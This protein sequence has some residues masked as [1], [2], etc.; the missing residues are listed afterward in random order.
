MIRSSKHTI[1]FTNKN[2]LEI[3]HSFLNE[4]RRVAQIIVDDIWLNGYDNFIPSKDKL[5]LPHYLDYTRFNAETFLSARSKSSLVNQIRGALLSASEK[6]SKCLFTIKKLKES[7]KPYSKLEKKT[8]INYKLVKPNLSK[9]NPELSSKNIDIVE[10][11]NSFDYFIRL[12]STGLPI[13]KIPLKHTK[14]STKWNS[15]G[16]R[17]NSVLLTDDAV[18]IRYEIEPAENNKTEVVAID[19]GL[20]TVCT[21]SNGE[22]SPKV[23]KHNHSLETI[24]EEMSRKKKG[25]KAF[26]RCQDHRKNFINWSVNQLNLSGIK[27]LRL[28]KI[29]NINFK[30]KRNRFMG[31][32][33][34]TL[35]RDKLKSTCEE[36]KVSFIEQDSTYRSQRCS[37][38]GIVRSAN[39]KGKSYECKH[40]NNVID[41]DLNAALNHKIDLPDLHW[42]LR[43]KK[44][45]KGNGFYW[46]KTGLFNF[47]GEEF[48]VPHSQK[49]DSLL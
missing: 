36:L 47:N 29:W 39:R 42:S 9:L 11:S 24:L 5:E 16:K 17:M 49:E 20:K 3:Y 32:W 10:N 23:D 38:C 40:C 34:N 31:H 4:Y 43:G 30:S 21:L 22:I 45:N 14:V 12:K 8:N 37:C 7:G 26:K 27:E 44:F 41:A 13:I 25:S 2:K 28:E 18:M 1:K 35:I 6:R 15:K 46:L 48:R 33:T 19:Q